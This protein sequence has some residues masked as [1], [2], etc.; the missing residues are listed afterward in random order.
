MIMTALLFP[1]AALLSAT[2]ALF[3]PN[4]AMEI[5]SGFTMENIIPLLF[6][7][8]VM[9]SIAEELSFR[10]AILTASE[11]MSIRNAAIL[12]GVLFGLIHMN[13]QQIPYATFLGIV[14]ALFVLHTK[15]IFSS[16]LAH[17]VVNA[18]N[19]LLAVLA[20]SFPSEVQ[21]AASAGTNDAILPAMIVL[22]VI[23]TFCYLG[24]LYV[25]NRFKLHNIQRHSD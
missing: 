12:N 5:T 10:G 9:P 11:G 16:I 2:M 1:T 15:S 13:P 14:F 4:A 24:F 8:A 6:V 22:A 19:V 7:L 23:A 25:F 17:F 3:Y 20:A 21:E 18:P